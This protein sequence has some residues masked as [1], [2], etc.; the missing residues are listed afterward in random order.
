MS[1]KAVVVDKPGDP[2]KAEVSIKQVEESQLP[3]G[4][5][6]VDVEYTTVN[7][8]DGICMGPGMGLVHSYPHVPGID[9]AGTVESSSDDRYKPGDKVVL[10]GWNV[11]ESRW[12]GYAAKARVEAGMLVPLPDT[13]T[14]R[15]AMA[16]GTAGLAAM[17][18]V[19]AL[20]D[21]GLK[22]GNG[23]VLVTGAAGGVG[24]VA[25]AILRKLGY[26][27]IAGVPGDPS[28]VDYIKS[29]GATQIVA[30]ED[31]KKQTDDLFE[32][33]TWAG[34]IDVVSGTTLARLLKQ[35]KYGGSVASVGFA[36]GEH[37]TGCVITPFI[38]RAVNLLGIDTVLQPYENRLRAWQRLATDLPVEDLESMIHPAV[39]DDLP[40]LGIDIM[41]GKVR[42]RV[43]CDVKA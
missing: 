36:G 2:G 25:L 37:I 38:V 16:I 30:R 3:P 20:E 32:K 35:M 13:M 6:L 40:Q 5:V 41:H 27:E 42:G 11:G 1:F 29:L 34:A 22:P 19:I 43:V 12:G 28:Q 7:Y 31:L 21:H 14:P 39:F 18:S 9:F 4:N 26:P 23:P 17:M 33:E 24:S 8:K 15:T 10:T